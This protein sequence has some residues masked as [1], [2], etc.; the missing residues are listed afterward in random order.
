MPTLHT[1]RGAR[2]GIADAVVSS[3]LSRVRF[4]APRSLIVS[5]WFWKRGQ[6]LDR[7][8]ERRRGLISHNPNTPTHSWK[9]RKIF[10][11]SLFVEHQQ[12]HTET[13]LR[14]AGGEPLSVDTKNIHT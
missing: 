8:A 6:G 9:K 14:A 5:A 11:R 1:S 4:N 12:L 2:F 13:I 10:F 7:F 3:S